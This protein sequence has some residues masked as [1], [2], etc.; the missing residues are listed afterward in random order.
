SHGTDTAQAYL[1][2]ALA[3]GLVGRPYSG[4][5]TIT[6]Q[7]NGQGGREH[8]QK[9][10]QL[11]GYRRLD[12]PV[13]RAHVAAVW[14]VDP[15]ELP[16]PGRSAY[17]MLDRLGTPGGVQVLLVLA[18]NIAVSAPHSNRVVDRLGALDFLVV[19][20]IFRSETAELA[21]VVLP[22]AQWAEEE[23]TMTNLEGRVLRRKR[24]LPP[25]P[26][27]KS[28][29]EVLAELAGRLGRGG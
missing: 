27:V 11:P 16:G 15:D 26:D 1:N 5:G 14:G 18:S 28:D 8:G 13:A 21:D 3:L 29:L 24:V 20:D 10:D 2:L 23:G 25:P 22:T 7:G 6:G 19:S 12:D 17:E 4:Y 9:A